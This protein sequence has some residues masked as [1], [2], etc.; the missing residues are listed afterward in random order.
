MRIKF[1][2]ISFVVSISII[3][4]LLPINYLIHF[5]SDDSYFYLKTALNFSSGIGS[6]FDGINLTN[7][8]HPLWFLILSFY[9]FFIGL[10]L[11]VSPELLLQL[12]FVLITILNGLSIYLLIKVVDKLSLFSSKISYYG[13]LIIT[14]P[15][16][17][18]YVLGTE[19]NIIVLLFILYSYFFVNDDDS[20]NIYWK[21]RAITLAL[22]FLSRIDLG[23]IAGIILILYESRFLNK[24]KIFWMLMIFTSTVL[25]YVFINKMIFDIYS[26]ISSKYKFSLDLISNL[27]F[28][29]TPLSNPIDFGM[30]SLFIIGG[31]LYFSYMKIYKS[32]LITNNI[33][34]IFFFISFVFLLSNLFFNKQ[35]V[36]E[37]YYIFPVLSSLIL[38]FYT[39]DKL[40]FSHILFYLT[41]PVSVIYFTLFRINYYNHDSALTFAKELKEKVKESEIVFQI[42]YSGLIGFFSE[43]KVVNGDGLINSFDY[44]NVLKNNQLMQYLKVL[45]PDYFVFYDFDKE[46]KKEY[47]SY[48]FRTFHDYEFRFNVDK[49][50][51]KQKL[52]YGGIFRKK[53][54]NF[55][56]VYTKDLFI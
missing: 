21:A 48:T 55:Y 40:N 26:S 28:F 6:S 39:I 37:W 7:G 29:P 50:R 52:L 53:Y 24:N 46:I 44:Y 15:F 1:L 4:F 42:D 30:L 49:L 47:L 27:Q 45:K 2:I 23:I 12:T 56:L 9:Y 14:L 11:N 33:F 34:E 18:F 51:L 41:I 22:I 20:K 43:R 16:T 32:K 25:I 36:R 54:G 35:G 13:L 5:T 10:L 38:L 3:W 19:K 31:L 17:F 8:Y